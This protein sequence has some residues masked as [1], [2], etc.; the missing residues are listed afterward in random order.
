MGVY[1]GL[2]IGCGT[3][4]VLIRHATY[5]VQKLHKNSLYR[6]DYRQFLT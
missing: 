6:K 3:L 1:V 2:R 5:A 4:D